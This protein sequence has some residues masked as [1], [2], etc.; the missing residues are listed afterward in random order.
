MALDTD[1]SLTTVAEVLAYLGTAP[2]RNAFWVYCDAS[3]A[4][5]A[6]VEITDTAAVLIITGGADA[7]TTTLTFADAATD[8]LSELVAVINGTS[9]WAAG[10]LANGSA[11]TAN[12]IITGALNV[13]G[14][15]N[16]QTLKI[17][18]DYLVTALINR[19]SDLINR[20]CQ[21][22]L[23]SQAYTNERYTAGGN[24]LYLDN[25]PVTAVTQLCNGTANA[26]RIKYTSTTA[27]N[28]YAVVSTTGVNTIVDGTAGTEITFTDEATMSDMA[29]AINALANWGAVVVNSDYNSYPSS[30][31]IQAFNRPAL[32]A[33]NYLEVPDDPLSGYTLDE[34]VGVVYLPG[35]FVYGFD[36]IFITYTAGYISGS[37]PAALEQACIEI[38]KFKLESSNRDG[39]LKSEEIGK[40]YKYERFGLSDITDILPPSMLAELD[41]FRS[42][43]VI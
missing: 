8:T 12:M 37:I 32:N 41:L 22:N 43:D 35:G 33:Y 40:V 34:D 1:I 21:R 11:D 38:V 9:G 29:T 28:A 2:K 4:T 39:G 18:D 26:I 10:I 31:L 36:A 6:T 24:K 23:K 13:L 7:G 5:A 25:Y 17:R 30:D 20:Y 42:R 15:E 3:D 27:R 16:K 19:A 14:S